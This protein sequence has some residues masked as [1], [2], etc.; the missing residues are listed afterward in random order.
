MAPIGYAPACADP[1]GLFLLAT[2]LRDLELF[3]LYNISIFIIPT[4]VLLW[5][6]QKCAAKMNGPVVDISPLD[7]QRM[8]DAFR[9]IS[10]IN[11]GA[12]LPIISFVRRNYLHESLVSELLAI[13]QLYC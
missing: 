8:T 2:L 10:A 12:D 9:T 4:H 1:W 5:K 13:N 7:S 11:T 3:S 6:A